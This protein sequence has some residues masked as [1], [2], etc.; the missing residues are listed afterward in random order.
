MTIR[1]GLCFLAAM[2]LCMSGCTGARSDDH[3]RGSV[4]EKE[5]NTRHLKGTTDVLKTYRY[6]ERPGDAKTPAD[7]KS[8]IPQEKT[9]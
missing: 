4:A 8:R 6:G 7:K 2:G 1:M 9:K 3:R 5:V